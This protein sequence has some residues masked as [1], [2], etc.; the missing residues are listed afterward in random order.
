MRQCLSLPHP[1]SGSTLRMLIESR[2]RL[3]TWSPESGYKRPEKV[4]SDRGDFFLEI[5]RDVSCELDLNSLTHK[6]LANL[7]A[8][9]AAEYTSIYMVDGSR[10]LSDVFTWWTARGRVLVFM[11][12]G[13]G[14]LFARMTHVMVS[15]T[16]TDTHSA[17]M[18]RPL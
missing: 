3:P 5:V 4:T 13:R 15:V 17:R 10:M 14:L 9:A 11:V 12:G 8:L 18:T 2:V 1:T 7:S 16:R 6:V